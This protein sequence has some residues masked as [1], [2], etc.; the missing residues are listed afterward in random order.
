MYNPAA[1]CGTV[2]GIGVADDENI[3]AEFLVEPFVEGAPGPHVT[4]AVEAFRG[5][6]LPVDLGPFASTSSGGLDAIVDAIAAMIRA[7]MRNGASSV[8]LRVAPTVEELP[9]PTLRDAL[10]DI[11]RMAE[12][13]IGT[14][15]S[16]WNRAEKQRVVRMLD[17]RGA[18]LLRGAVDDIAEIMGVSRITIYN[19]LNALERVSDG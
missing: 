7:A 10:G 19:Y 14:T 9:V 11:L 17:E 4:A 2:P 8:Q 6:D 15:A 18:F 3:A 5:Q 13:E 1:G 16:R 12:R